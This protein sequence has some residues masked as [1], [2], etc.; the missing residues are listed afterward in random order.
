MITRRSTPVVS[1]V[2]A[3]APQFCGPKFIDTGAMA[4]PI[5]VFGSGIRR[6]DGEA[7]G[8]HRLAR[9]PPRGVTRWLATSII[10][11]PAPA[12]SSAGDELLQNRGAVI[13]A[14][15]AA[16][17]IKNNARFFMFLNGFCLRET[18]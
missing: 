2:W 9:T 13:Q 5:A 4:V 11:P 10:A 17:Q 12:L 1:K 7:V 15:P 8:G 6:L 14:L 3:T 16:S 18:A